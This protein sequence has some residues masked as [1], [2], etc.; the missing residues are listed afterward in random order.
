MYIKY[1]TTMVAQILQIARDGDWWKNRGRTENIIASKLLSTIHHNYKFSPNIC[2]LCLFIYFLA[3]YLYLLQL[4]HIPN[5]F[6]HY[7]N[8]IFK[9]AKV[10][11][12]TIL[13]TLLDILPYIHNFL[14]IAAY[15]SSHLPIFS[16]GLQTCTHLTL[17]LLQLYCWPILFS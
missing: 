8:S 1:F 4:C 11:K 5:T 12:N 9:F 16:I 15:I 14:R 3:L 13:S 17:S 2:Y 7:M 6:A 10:S